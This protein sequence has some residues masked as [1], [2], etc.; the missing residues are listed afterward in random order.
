MNVSHDSE[1]LFAWGN[2]QADG[3]TIVLYLLPFWPTLN[4]AF[5]GSLRSSSAADKAYSVFGSFQ[6]HI[7]G[8]IMVKNQ[9]Y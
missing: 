5:R 3:E 6:G 1:Y 4:N 8:H 7:D 9:N 2:I